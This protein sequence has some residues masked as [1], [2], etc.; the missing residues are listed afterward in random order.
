[1]R[2]LEE[3]GSEPVDRARYRLVQT[4]QVFGVSLVKRAYRQNFDPQF[5]DDA[6]VMEA[7][8]ETIHLVEGDPVNIKITN[9]SDLAMAEFFSL[10]NSPE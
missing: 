7:M 6:T 10:S 1:M 4:P 2:V 5:T 3:A 9:A 8:G